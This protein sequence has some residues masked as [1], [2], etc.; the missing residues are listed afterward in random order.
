MSWEL[1]EF[2]LEET[3]GPV[4]VFNFEARV[5]VDDG[6]PLEFRGDGIYM[7]RTRQLRLNR[8]AELAG[9][10]RERF[11]PPL[12]PYSPKSKAVHFDA[13]PLVNELTELLRQR[14]SA[15]PLVRKVERANAAP[16]PAMGSV[17]YMLRWEH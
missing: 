5:N 7:S 9:A 13:T 4:Q 1:S 6:A 11:A 17:A 2:T 16:T 15:P 14:V 10:I 12:P 8:E 3:S